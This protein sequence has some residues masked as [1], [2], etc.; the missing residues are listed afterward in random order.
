MIAPA[1]ALPLLLLAIGDDSPEGKALAY[2]NAEVPRWSREHHCYSC[3]NNGDAARALYSA[4]K[5]GREIPREA[6]LDTDRWLARPEA[7]DKNG[8][9]GPFSDKRLARLQ[10]AA[11]LGS[12]VEAGRVADRSPLLRASARLAEDQADDGSWTIDG[13]QDQIGSPTTLGRPLAT[14]LGRETL[15]IADPSTHRPKIDR[16]DAWLR[17]L[18]VESVLDAS[19]VLLGRAFDA[20]VEGLNRRD[21]ALGLLKRGQSPEGGWGPFATAPTEVFDTA[22][23]LLALDRHH[24]RPGV[25]A[26]IAKGRGYLIATQHDDG[27]WTETTRPTGAESY[28]QR[29]STTGW[30]TM[31]LLT[32]KRP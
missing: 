23:A 4:I 24:D 6:T 16:A 28:A 2:L 8:G 7:W 15:R 13:D 11:A 20:S 31:A 19:V 21:K 26:M 17:R 5:L 10:F 32:V 22:L 1:V 3:H 27:S 29:L 30:A 12:A 18:P 9:D 14:W 25:T